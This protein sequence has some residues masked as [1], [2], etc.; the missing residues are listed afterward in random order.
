MDL[1]DYAQCN[2]T[3]ILNTFLFCLKEE[4]NERKNFNFITRK[5][6]S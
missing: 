5:K 4:R 2:I 6:L 1:I 3:D